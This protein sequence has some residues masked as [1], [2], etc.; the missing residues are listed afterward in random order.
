[1]NKGYYSSLALGVLVQLEDVA[2]GVIRP[3]QVRVHTYILPGIRGFIEGLRYQ[4]R[5]PTRSRGRC[6][7]PE[8]ES[9]P[10]GDARSS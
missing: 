9:C 10:W 4:F 3:E 8:G 6:W 5:V 1:M 2:H 7:A